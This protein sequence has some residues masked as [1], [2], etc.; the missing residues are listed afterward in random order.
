MGSAPI[1]TCTGCRRK[2]SQ[3]ELIRIVRRPDGRP[4]LNGD[5]SPGRG[6]YVCFDRSC[7]ERALRSGGLKRALRVEGPIPPALV[8]DL[9]R[10]AATSDREGF[11]G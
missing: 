11:D 8:E 10:R 1:R 6:A 9:L 3:A 2:R 7:V 5:R 4:S